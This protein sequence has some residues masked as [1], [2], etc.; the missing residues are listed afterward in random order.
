MT[1]DVAIGVSI[2]DIIGVSL[3]IGDVSS[4]SEE[5]IRVETPVGVEG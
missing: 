2:L 1:G 4:I 3:V 5:A